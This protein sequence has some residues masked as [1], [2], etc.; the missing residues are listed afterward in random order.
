MTFSEFWLTFCVCV[1][2]CACGDEC[3]AQEVTPDTRWKQ[4]TPAMTT[5][6]THTCWAGPPDWA[7][8]LHGS[9]HSAAPCGWGP[10]ASTRTCLN[11]TIIMHIYHALLNTL[12]AHIIHINLNTIVYTHV[13]QSCQ[14]N[15]YKVL[16]GNTHP[17]THMTTSI[18]K[19]D[20]K[21]WKVQKNTIYKDKTQHANFL[22]NPLYQATKPKTRK[23]LS[24]PSHFWSFFTI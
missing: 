7:G 4:P 14:K 8:P 18:L 15:L 16:Y 1:C 11:R 10:G 13:E 23:W 3:Y 9:R 12:S 19:Q 20:P 17:H 22:G 21:T 5:L 2:V 6:C 24:S